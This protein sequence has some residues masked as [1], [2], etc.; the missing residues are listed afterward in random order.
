VKEVNGMAK[1]QEMVYAVVGAGDFTLQKVRDLTKVDRKSSQKVYK[2]FVKRGKGL[3]TKV[4]NAAA[5]KQAF[6]QTK[7]ARTQVKAAATSVGRA[8]RVGAKQG[9]S[10]AA[11]QTKTARTQVKAA[12][13]S[14]GKAAKANARATR[15]AVKAS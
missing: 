11:A 2:D 8:I 4:K 13:T 12:T 7:T 1:A 9:P 14:V 15:T 3:S 10:R 6:E 5:T